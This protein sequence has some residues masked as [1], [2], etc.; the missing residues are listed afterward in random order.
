MRVLTSVFFC[1]R[2]AALVT[3]LAIGACTVDPD[4]KAPQCPVALLRPDAATLTRYDGRGTDLTNLVVS[5]EL[6]NVK[7]TCKGLLG[8]N[9]IG[10]TAHVEMI[11]TRGPAAQ[12]RDIDLAYNVAVTY[13]GELRDHLTKVQHITFP[14]NVDTV[15]VTGEDLYFTL[16]A[17]RGL[18]GPDYNIYYVFALTPEEL[19]ANR[20]ALGQH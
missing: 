20:R 15:H 18:G 1:G 3:V 9:N 14:V 12:G 2:A 8:H 6:V 16:S 11:V 4:E 5:A 17:P 13:K 7:G 19:A 10:A